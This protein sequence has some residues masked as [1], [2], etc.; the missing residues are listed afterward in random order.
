MNIISYNIRG[1]GNT[2]KKRKLNRLLEKG[3]VDV[4]FLQES[5][6]Q[7][8]ND[9]VVKKLR[10]SEEIEQSRKNSEGFSRGLIILW[11]FG[12]IQPMF[13]FMG[14]WFIRIGTI[15]QGNLCYF[16]NVYSSCI[17]N[18]KRALWS[19]LVSIK[20]KLDV[21]E[22]IIWGDFN[23]V[24]CSSKTQGRISVRNDI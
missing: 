16:I 20:S 23:S 9:K 3:E 7:N 1:C 19:S 17:L 5:R 4:C 12:S 10:R 6:I 13:C 14:E 8:L 18:R 11:K 2:I 24:K 15:M 21:G 22:W